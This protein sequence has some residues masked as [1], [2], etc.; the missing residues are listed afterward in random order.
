M[1]PW[2][3]RD[4]VNPFHPGCSYDTLRR[5]VARGRVRPDT[6]IRGPTTRQFWS[7]ARNTP[8]VAHLL[9]ACHA[10]HEAVDPSAHRCP[11]CNASFIVPNDRQQLG[12]APIQM[13]PGDADPSAV[14]DAAFGPA[15]PAAPPTAAANGPMRH[16]PTPQ[17]SSAQPV[18]TGPVAGPEQASRVMPAR[19]VRKRSKGPMVAVI[20]SV[21]CAVIVLAAVVSMNR[22]APG[23][24]VAAADESDPDLV[25]TETS[26][27]TRDA[28]AEVVPLVTDE[29]AESVGLPGDADNAEALA[30]IEPNPNQALD[31]NELDASLDVSPSN[32]PGSPTPATSGTQPQSAASGPEATT[33]GRMTLSEL[34]AARAAWVSAGR[35]DLVR[36]ADRRAEQLRLRGAFVRK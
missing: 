4:Q 15:T 17:L 21:A 6:V 9:G 22:A 23:S 16:G 13:L 30:V 14:A 12:L 10:C 11:S 27:A 26:P 20:A 1:G 18:P 33:I 35:D 32:A 31:D 28:D 5:L 19:P 25:A 3:I 2:S 7:F 24:S 29:A 34:E 36:A 8:G